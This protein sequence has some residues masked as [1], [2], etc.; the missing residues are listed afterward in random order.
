MAIIGNIPYFQT[1]PPCF[2]CSAPESHQWKIYEK[3]N[4]PMFLEMIHQNHRFEV[5]F[6]N[7]TAEITWPPISTYSS[8]QPLQ[9]HPTILRHSEANLET[10]RPHPG[11]AKKCLWALKTNV[12][13][14]MYIYIYV[15]CITC[16]VDNLFKFPKGQSQIG[17]SLCTSR[18]FSAISS[19][20][21][22]KKAIGQACRLWC[23]A[24]SGYL[25][26]LWGSPA[27]GHTHWDL[28]HTMI[29]F[30]HLGN[31]LIFL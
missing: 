30:V 5:C 11:I 1:N 9:L 29:H 13:N 8:P 28:T 26:W 20:F 27:T 23:A 12:W 10:K 2:P 14:N 24:G 25:W 4:H 3:W 18:Q 15:T 16:I 19:N 17:H 6:F 31:S 22:E 21:F 7:L